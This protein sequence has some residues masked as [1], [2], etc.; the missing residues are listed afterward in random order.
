[1][2]MKILAIFAMLLLLMQPAYAEELGVVEVEL[3]DIEP[4]TGMFG[5]GHMFYGFKLMLEGVDEFITFQPEA[6]LLKK[7]QHAQLRLAEAKGEQLKNN[8]AYMEKALEQYQ[9]ALDKVD[10]D[11]A[12]QKQNRVIT[13]TMNASIDTAQLF[14][15]QQQLVLEQMQI[16]NPSLVGLQTAIQDTEQTM[17]QIEEHTQRRI[18]GTIQIVGLGGN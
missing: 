5:P 6:K 2:I 4:Y 18:N 15:E 11:I 13:A 8:V 16:L 17:E 10:K 1:M 14:M 3:I 7:M 9:R 12:K